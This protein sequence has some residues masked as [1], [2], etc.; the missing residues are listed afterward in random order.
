MKTAKELTA[1]LKDV[2]YEYI[3]ADYYE[4]SGAYYE[5]DAEGLARA[6]LEFLNSAPKKKP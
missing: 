2:Q 6:I 5:L 3:S 4:D 1:W